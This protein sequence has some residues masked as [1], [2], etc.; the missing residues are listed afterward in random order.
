[1]ECTDVVLYFGHAY[2]V[3]INR[4]LRK[5]PYPLALRFRFEPEVGQ[6]RQVTENSEVLEVCIILMRDINTPLLWAEVGS[7]DFEVIVRVYTEDG[8]ATGVGE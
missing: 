1:M 6:A 7:D 2:M 4:S 8:T 5:K 3:N